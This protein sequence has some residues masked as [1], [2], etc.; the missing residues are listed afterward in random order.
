MDAIVFQSA[1]VRTETVEEL[2][3]EAHRSDGL[4]VGL[5]DL[6]E[7]LGNG[8]GGLSQR[9][10]LRGVQVEEDAGENRD[11]DHKHLMLGEDAVGI[12]FRFERESEDLRG[13]VNVR[14]IADA[15]DETV[16]T[17]TVTAERAHTL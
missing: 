4:D 5:H 11:K 6:S 15:V 13:E 2:R 7:L 12:F 17:V 1:L 10:R 14:K 3:D 16:R 9:E 8:A